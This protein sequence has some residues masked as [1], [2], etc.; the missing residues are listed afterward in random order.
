MK[1]FNNIFLIC[2]LIV[3][4]I[5]TSCKEDDIESTP[6][7]N[8]PVFTINGVVGTEITSTLSSREGTISFNAEGVWSIK[9]DKIWISID[10]KTGSAGEH[11]INYT[12]ENSGVNYDDVAEGVISLVMGNQEFPIEVSRL[13]RE[14]EI[15]FM[16]LVEDGDN[17]VLE[18]ITSLDV[19]YNDLDRLYSAKINHVKANFDW[20]VSSLPE[21]IYDA[22]LDADGFELSYG[23][24]SGQII[25]LNLILNPEKFIVGAKMEGDIVFSSKGG[26]FSKAIKVNFNGV[27]ETFVNLNNTLPLGATL[28]DE[29]YVL[30][31][32]NL[33]ESDQLGF[34]F[35]VIAANPE[36]GVYV[37]KKDQWG[38]EWMDPDNEYVPAW[39]HILKASSRAGESTI[40]TNYTLRVDA[41]LGG[42]R[43]A[44]VYILPNIL[45]KDIE[46]GGQMLDGASIKAEYEKY[47]VSIITQQSLSKPMLTLG[48]WGNWD[49]ILTALTDDSPGFEDYKE[50]YNTENIAKL[51]LGAEAST[52]VVNMLGYSI[53]LMEPK[54]VSDG[55]AILDGA[56]PMMMDSWSYN[57]MWTP[58]NTGADIETVLLMQYP[59]DDEESGA[60]AGDNY[61]VLVITQKP[62]APM[63]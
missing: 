63:E 57:F 6:T 54:L 40:I 55:T 28:T 24:E 23:G 25:S 43:M 14:R 15:E 7:Y 39:M 22:G 61:G 47:F 51:E 8:A 4:A 35:N 20:N 59:S 53:N 19:I 1:R 48:E 37:F 52:A 30:E 62:S 27:D 16:N 2:A 5:F 36:V 58:N 3:G 41:N 38:M 56:E 33:E 60:A 46:W 21:W 9:V 26:E 13:P 29:G 50:K 11:T 32:L 31:G 42:T 49:V 10:K 17:V 44:E 12:I 34:D 18:P 45:A